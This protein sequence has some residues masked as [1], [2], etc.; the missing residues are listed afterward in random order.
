MEKPQ[1]LYVREKESHYTATINGKTYTCAVGRN[2][3]IAATDKKEGDG[4]TPTG[5]FPLRRLF[6]RDDI[7][8]KS[9]L[10][11]LL[12]KHALKPS[13][14]WCDEPQHFD[15]NKRVDLLTFDLTIS[16]EKLW[17]DDDVYHMIIEVGYNDDP[18][19]PFKGSAI[20]IHIAREGYTGTAGCVAFSEGDL[21]EIIA[22]LSP[23]SS[24]VIQ[25]G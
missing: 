16:H 2:G 5:T 19:V 24:V 7:Y 12:P 21:R 4:S 3:F 13:D 1:H 11:T 25:G 10:E 15:Y 14:G 8:K 18:V 22:Y 17:R 20:F 6:Y 9:D 23:D